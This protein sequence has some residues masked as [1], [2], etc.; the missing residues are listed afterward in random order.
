MDI[1]LKGGLMPPEQIDIDAI[2]QALRDAYAAPFTN[3]LL[4][5]FGAVV[6]VLIL[7]AVIIN[8]QINNQLKVSE[9]HAENMDK[10]RE[11]LEKH[12]EGQTRIANTL[13]GLSKADELTL[14][15]NEKL[16]SN[17]IEL[18]KH[19]IHIAQQVRVTAEKVGDTHTAV[20]EGFKTTEAHLEAM[21]KKL[22]EQLSPLIDELRESGNRLEILVTAVQKQANKYENTESKIIGIL[23]VARTAPLS[24]LEKTGD[25]LS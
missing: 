25:I 10:W 23:T 9:R 20:T 18:S 4:I 21:P 8:R 5:V 7:L 16:A 17:L 11:M 1:S 12:E 2:S 13:S 24:Q 15:I 3:L 14:Q 22:A 6:I 19:Q